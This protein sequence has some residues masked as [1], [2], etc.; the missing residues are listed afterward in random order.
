MNTTPEIWF[1]TGSQHL[2]GEGPLRQV[3]A[4]SK[5]LVDQLNASGRLPL[6][7]VFKPVL[8]RPE[9]VRATLTEA[10]G[11]AACSGSASR[12]STWPRS[13]TGTFPGRRS[14]WIS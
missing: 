14:T 9:E 3:A 5:S 12:S 1:L 6:R 4:N 11:D 10:N 2:Y 8:T 7:L 13:S